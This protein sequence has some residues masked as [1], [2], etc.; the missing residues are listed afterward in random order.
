MPTIV[1]EAP[2]PVIKE[3]NKCKACNNLDPRGHAETR[4]VSINGNQI[5]TLLLGPRFPAK[6]CG[7]CD[8][9]FHAVVEFYPFSSDSKYERTWKVPQ[10][11]A[12]LLAEHYP[13]SLWV[14]VSHDGVIEHSGWLDI[15]AL[16]DIPVIP[17]IGK[18]ISIFE[19][20]DSQS[21]FTFIQKCLSD[22]SEHAGCKISHSSALPR[23]L[24]YL[25]GPSDSFELQSNQRP[26]IKLC[27]TNGQL[28]R[29]AALSHCWGSNPII[30]TKR[31]NVREFEDEI[32]WC[33][34]PKTFQ[35]AIITALRL[36]IRYLWIDSLCIIQDDKT[37]WDTEAARMGAIYEN[38]YLTIAAAS[39]PSSVFPF[40]G[41]RTP[42]Y[43]PKTLQFPNPQ[44]LSNNINNHTVYGSSDDINALRVRQGP[45]IHGINLSELSKPRI[46]GPLSTR[47]WALQERVLSSRIVHFTDEGIVWECRTSIQNEDQRRLFPG[48]LQK[49]GNFSNIAGKIQPVLLHPNRYGNDVTALALY[50]CSFPRKGILI[51]LF[52]S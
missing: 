49:W 44:R 19:S 34:L 10:V 30:A 2:L 47:G 50:I 40:L 37:D 6:D 39:S 45:S 20:S 31:T 18:G 17:S 5:P 1:D 8:L 16:S 22:C 9:L 48:H 41:P 52:R 43:R 35:D 7:Y 38:A 42:N 25:D 21:C 3:L 11:V 33:H 36:E 13:I 32:H 4:T 23:R 14:P 27:E 15:Y 46:Y 26:K 12:I 29:Y 28:H 24:L 51:L